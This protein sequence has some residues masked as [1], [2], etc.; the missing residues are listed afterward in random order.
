MTASRKQHLLLLYYS[1]GH[2]LV[3]FTCAFLMIS[4]TAVAGEVS[5]FC[6]LIYNFCAFALQMPAGLCADR[7]NRN[8]AVAVAGLALTLSAFGLFSLPLLCATVLGIGNCLYHVGG[9]VDV[10]HFS[11]RRQWMLGVFVSPGAI[12]LFFGGA[13]ARERL[14]SLP[15]GF[16][17]I[18]AASALISL[19]LHLTHSLKKP[20]GNAPPS[21]EPNGR[22]PAA[23]IVFLL[24]VVV[25]RSYVGMTLSFPWKTGIWS[26][27]SVLGLALGKAAGGFLADRIG[28]VRA[29]SLTLSLC[30]ILF[31]FSDQPLCGLLAVFLFNMTMPLT[32]FA[33]ARL[34]PGARGFAFGTLTFAL[35][36]GYLPT[37]LGLPVPFVGQGGWY[38]AEAVLSLI[39]LI[40]GLWA[41]R[42]SGGDPTS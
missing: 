7:L 15:L 22:A 18:L 9:G 13:L 19:A 3:D 5:W 25:L 33:M 14:L 40:A 30:A 24:L 1:C 27:L 31:L 16:L 32:L 28:P 21:V 8:A 10:L 35:F 11:E 34:F 41:C 38:A 4:L 36:L 6:L 17:A 20:S 37:H 29:S 23:A 2:F 12:G 42:P 26:L 39:L